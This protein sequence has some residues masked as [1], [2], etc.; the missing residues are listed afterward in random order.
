M[1]QGGG[2]FQMVCGVGFYQDRYSAEKLKARVKAARGSR[3]YGE[4]YSCRMAVIV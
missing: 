2:I 1:E 3:G 4:E